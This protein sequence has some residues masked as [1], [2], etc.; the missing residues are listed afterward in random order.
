[1]VFAAILDGGLSLIDT[2]THAPERSRCLQNRQRD[3]A[4]YHQIDFE[5]EPIPFH[6]V[7]LNYY[8]IFPPVDNFRINVGVQCF[9]KYNRHLFHV[10]SCDYTD[11]AKTHL[12]L[13][14]L[15]MLCYFVSDKTLPQ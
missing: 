9:E 4:A 2:H 5:A 11:Q 12:L 15:S 13:F 10:K 3:S 1:M 7:A 14:L 6:I 8:A